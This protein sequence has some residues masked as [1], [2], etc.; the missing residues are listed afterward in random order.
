MCIA[1]Y[2]EA[3]SPRFAGV[4]EDNT[5]PDAVLWNNDGVLD[6]PNQLGQRMAA[7]ISNWC[8]PV[9]LT[10]N[11][12][13]E[14]CSI[15]EASNAGKF[16]VTD[17]TPAV[18]FAL[19]YEE[20]VTR[21]GFLPVCVQAAGEDAITATFS[22]I[23]VEN[24]KVRPRVWN[25]TGSEAGTQIASNVRAA[26]TDS[27]IRQAGVAIVYKKRLVYARGFNMAEDSWPQAEPTTRFRL[28]SCSKTITALAV[29]QLI[30]EG[31]LSMDDRVQDIL[32][33]KTPDGHG[34]FDPMFNVITVGH[35][36]EHSS[37]VQTDT[38]ES[39]SQLTTAF[40]N[41]GRDV[42]LPVSAED[43]DSFIATLLLVGP[44]GLTFVY[45]N[46]GY[47]LLGRV[48]NKLRGTSRP[49][50]AYQKHLFDPLQITRIR[51]ARSLIADQEP[52]EARYQDPALTVHTS[53]FP[54]EKL[55]PNYYGNH[56]LEIMD[57]DGGLTGA[58][59][60][61][62]RLVAI[63]TSTDDSP[64]LKRQTI[65]EKFTRGVAL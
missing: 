12:N 7:Q 24:D 60:D 51:R 6:S 33:L 5:G 20:W 2:G 46:C 1:S 57:G 19:A 23:F 35:L 48:V 10:L 36:I 47:Y 55:V 18:G 29:M 34:P 38:F 65:V 32:N 59:V 50:D 40:S 52:G 26:M 44:P 43:T 22:A 45:N 17:A 61:V 31:K 49:I 30:E 58:A 56:H 4:W 8:R 54:G 42:T 21:K 64:V 13:L 37:G 41:A 9:F 16:H 11:K 39:L 62:A 15:F 3:D 28:A 63:L 14:F 25:A 53:A 27:I